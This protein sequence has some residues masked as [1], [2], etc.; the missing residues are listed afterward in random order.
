MQIA[1]IDGRTLRYRIA[2]DPA[3]SRTLVL[4]HAFPVGAGLF[5][6]QED[7]F[8]DWR[9]VIPALPGFDGS[10]LNGETSIDAYAADVLRLLDH[11]RVDRA[12]F[13]GVS[14]GGY[15]IFGVLRQHPARL[16]AIVLADT[17]SAGDAPEARAGRERLLHTARTAGPAAIAEEMLPK[18]LG[19]ST[20]ARGAHVGAVVRRLIEGQTADGI[21]AAVQVLMRR[22]DSTPLLASIAVPTL[23]VVGR[24]DT[25]TPPAEMERMAAGIVGAMFVQIDEAGHLANLENP[26]AFNNA[27]AGWLASL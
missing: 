12:V 24:E 13:A 23:V 25:L 18:L 5:V 1:T 20:R 6:P 27:V 14:L 10:D 22:P 16:R 7:A 21:A 19:E 17:R 3:A 8:P 11:L 26:T 9:V 15:L 2:G 4:V